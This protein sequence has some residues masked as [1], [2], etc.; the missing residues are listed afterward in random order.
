MDT[1]DFR[2]KQ[3]MLGSSNFDEVIEDDARLID[4]TMFIKEFMLD[5]AEVAAIFRP[6]RFGK[7]LNLSMLKSFLSYGAKP[8]DFDRFKIGKEK[9]F[10]QDHCG[11]YPVVFL[12]LNACKGAT[13]EEMYQLIWFRITQMWSRHSSDLNDFLEDDYGL[14]DAM[15]PE[16]APENANNMLYRLTK[17]LYKKHKK[18]VIVLV[19]EY[20]APL[21]HAL[22]NG[23]LRQAANFFDLFYSSALK[24]NFALE[25]ACLMGVLDVR[26]LDVVTGLNN[27][28]VY[29]VSSQKYSSCFGFTKEEIAP[30]VE[31]AGL[32]IEE[33]INWYGGCRIGNGMV[34][35]PWSF[36]NCFQDKDLWS[37]WRSTAY[38]E[39]ISVVLTPKLKQD[40]KAAFAFLCQDYNKELSVTALDTNVKYSEQNWNVMYVLHLLVFTGYLSYGPDP[41]KFRTGF[42]KIPKEEIRHSWEGDINELLA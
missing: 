28:I 38:T 26:G 35:N 13:W 32:N 37:Y 16:F 3:M 8:S 7:S 10:V 22:R 29:P 25:K 21:N 19:D 4:K 27:I 18:K 42:V 24:G 17:T 40:L 23:Y 14:V 5:E 33:V 11:K 30:L 41:N 9:D 15:K 20:D 39:T 12:D 6:R 1:K 34:V 2:E 31:E 36:M